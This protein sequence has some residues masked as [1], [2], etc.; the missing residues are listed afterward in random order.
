MAAVDIVQLA[1]VKAQLN[2]TVGTWD[3]Q[4]ASF[5]TAASQM[6]VNRVGPVNTA[7]AQFNEWYDGGRDTIMLRQQPVSAVTSVI[8]VF[9]SQTSYAL[10]YQSLLPGGD[11]SAWG[12]TTDLSMG[13]V[14]RR[15]AGVAVPFVSGVRNVNV[16]YAG[17]FASPPA[18]IQL[19]V[20]LLVKHMW[21]TMRGNVKVPGQ[22]GNEWNPAMGFA[23]PARVKEIA[24]GYMIPGIG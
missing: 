14:V 10:T 4:L 17:G 12:Y 13:T 9:S 16:Q 23:W 22:G 19:A 5:I 18:D 8:E 6:W 15:A 7:A 20:R 1:D 11:N 24:A 3:T 21:E 2:I